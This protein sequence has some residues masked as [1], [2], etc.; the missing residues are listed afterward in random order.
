VDLDADAAA[1]YPEDDEEQRLRW[2]DWGNCDH[3]LWEQGEAIVVTG[4]FWGGHSRGVLV[5]WFAPDGGKR[6]LC[7]LKTSGDPVV[8]TL[9]ADEPELCRAVA[10]GNQEAVQWAPSV[11]ISDNQ[12]RGP[13]STTGM[14]TR[15]DLDQDGEPDLVARLEYDSGA[16]CGYHH[17]WL[18]HAVPDES[19]SD[20]GV[21]MLLRWKEGEVVPAQ[22]GNVGP[23]RIEDASTLAELLAQAGDGAIPGTEGS[24]SSF[25]LDVFQF[26]GKPYVLGRGDDSSAKVYSVWAGQAK[27]WCTYQLLPIHEIEV[28]YPIESWKRVAR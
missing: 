14:V 6:P 22:G 8:K 7:Y 24:A 5:S 25:K 20:Q 19:K 3:F 10:E 26:R 9:S 13:S 17:E 15:I 4:S 12:R 28:F 2:A 27:T 16:G 1:P 21:S 11:D 18:A 23:V